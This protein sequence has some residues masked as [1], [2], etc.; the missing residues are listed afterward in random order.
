MS[1]KILKFEASWCGPCQQLSR[2]FA[3]NEDW[4]KKNN[5]VIEPVDIDNHPD[6]A[7]NHGVRGVPTLIIVDGDR[8]VA[9]RVGL[10]AW[11]KIQ[12]WITDNYI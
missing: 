3:A 10:D 11:P 9:R 7:T 5:V 4:L 6:D 1:R 12:Q 8:E 2:S